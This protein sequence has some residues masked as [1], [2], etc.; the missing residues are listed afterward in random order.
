[1][2]NWL[3]SLFGTVIRFIYYNFGQNFGVA[4]IIFTIFVKLLILP[5][6]IKQQR[7]MMHMQKLQ[8]KL[9]ELQRK[10]ANDKDK[11]GRETMELY[12]KYNVS[13]FGGCLPMIFQLVI[14]L[15]MVQIVYR[16]G[17]YVMGIEG[18]GRDLTEQIAAAQNAGM[19]FQFLRWW[20]LAEKPAFS[21]MP[22]LQQ[23]LTWV[24]PILATLATYFSG[25]LTQKT[26]GTAQ[27]T[28]PNQQENP[29]QQMSKSM[30]TMMPLMTLFFTFTLPASASLYWFISTVTQIV[31]QAF[32]TRILKIEVEEEGGSY[33]DK[34]NKKRKKR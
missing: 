16:P 4:L 7:S 9:N 33:H 15:V 3:Y 27:T 6:G 31:Q 18:L 5:L 34:H 8:P 14:L 17:T 1:M 23:L 32:L 11:L 22:T 10:Y 25:V 12:K 29:A 13:P 30:T 28:A 19:N 21:F 20:N 24:L 26:S 2:L